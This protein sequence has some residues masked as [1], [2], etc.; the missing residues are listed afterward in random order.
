[1]SGGESNQFKSIGGRKISLY[2]PH[3]I[4]CLPIVKFSIHH[5][6]LRF[7]F[8]RNPCDKGDA[9]LAILHFS[10]DISRYSIQ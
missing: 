5:P 10:T 7:R 6:A 2:F 8:A 4:V 3:S 1:M 9:L